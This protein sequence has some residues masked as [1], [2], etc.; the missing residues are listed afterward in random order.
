[1]ITQVKQQQRQAPSKHQGN[2]ERTQLSHRML[3]QPNT[4]P[5]RRDIFQLIFM[6]LLLIMNFLL[7]KMRPLLLKLLL[8]L[9]TLITPNMNVD[10]IRHYPIISE[11]NRLMK[12]KTVHDILRLL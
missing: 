11:L 9:R 12:P 1:M 4:Q 5:H 10:L 6:K 8:L 7:I 3:I 2:K